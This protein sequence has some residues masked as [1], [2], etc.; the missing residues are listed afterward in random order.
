[1]TLPLKG[2]KVVFPIDPHLQLWPPGLV[3]QV[4][5]PRTLWLA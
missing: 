2:I 4:Y 5:S 3:Q 1:L